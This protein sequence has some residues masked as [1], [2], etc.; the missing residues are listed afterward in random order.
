METDKIYVVLDPNFGERLRTLKGHAVWI[1]LSPRNEPTIRSVWK[2][3]PQADQFNGVT[4]FAF[5]EDLSSERQ[6]LEEIDTIDLHHGPYSTKSPYT[7]L[8][9]I[10]AQPTREIEDKLAEIGFSGFTRTAEGFVAHRSSEEAR[11]LRA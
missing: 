6:L 4:S 5:Y 7:L 11:K 3:N 2:E 10:G 1:T 9:V 8:E